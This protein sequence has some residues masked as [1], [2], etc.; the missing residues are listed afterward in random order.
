MSQK[1]D[2]CFQSVGADTLEQR[3][4]CKS[5][6]CTY[7]VCKDGCMFVCNKCDFKTADKE[8]VFRVGWGS[9]VC[10][11]CVDPQEDTYSLEP[12][13]DTDSVCAY[14]LAD[15][16]YCSEPV[17]S[18]YQYCHEH[19]SAPPQGCNECNNPFNSGPERQ[20]FLDDACAMGKFGWYADCCHKSLCKIDGGCRF[21]CYDCHNLFGIKDVYK[22]EKY[23]RIFLCKGCMTEGIQTYQ[24]KV[25]YGG[26]SFGSD[27]EDL[28]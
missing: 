17:H 27:T 18:C 7:M 21:V 26:D 24:I 28:F 13:E 2:K 23:S 9:I 15:N 16:T 8:E 25:W 19:S 1:C 10:K 14:V 3:Y 5:Q 20:L 22:V 4:G 12:Y 11:K 6:N